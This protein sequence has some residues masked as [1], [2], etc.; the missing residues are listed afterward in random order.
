MTEKENLIHAMKSG[1]IGSSLEL[2]EKILSE[3]IPAAEIADF[4]IQAIKEIG[5]AFEKFEIFLPEMMFASDAMVE[6]LKVLE[7]RL[8][9]EGSDL[10]KKSAKIIMATVKGDI[11]EIGK[12]IVIT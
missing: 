1:D 12:N 11:H 8:K 9:E 7:P 3:G 5:E 10:D 6:I 4:L 2:T